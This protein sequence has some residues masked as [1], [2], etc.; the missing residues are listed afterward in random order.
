MTCTGRL[1]VTGRGAWL[2]G[3]AGGAGIVDLLTGAVSPTG[4][5][6]ETI[7]V[8]LE[9]V[10]AFNAFPGELGTVRYGEGV[11]VGYR[12]YD[13]RGVAVAYPFGFGLSYTTFAIDGVAATVKGSGADASVTVTSRVTNTGSRAGVEVVQVYIG[14]P[15][16]R[17]ARPVRELKGFARVGLEP[18]ESRVVTIE[19][20]SRALAYWHPALGRWAVEGGAFTVE[21]GASSRDIA[22]TVSIDVEGEDLASPLGDMSTMGELRAHPVTG[23][24]AER[25]CAGLDATML[26]M[27][28]DFPL[29]VLADFGMVPGLNRGMV[30]R[31]IEYSQA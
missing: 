11:F 5:L 7:P 22:A 18:G 20:D 17:V 29:K 9:D 21:V 14:D 3:Q 16:S 2:S 13:L 23:A 31:L 6:A 25:L 15:E 26:S 27:V 12:H 19:L 4:R 1:G 24:E 10:P 28:D 8:R 30:T